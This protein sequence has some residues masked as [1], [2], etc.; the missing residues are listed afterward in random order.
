MF[1][2]EPIALQLISE[3]GFP[4]LISLADI[5][6]IDIQQCV[7]RMFN[8]LRE[9]GVTTASPSSSSSSSSSSSL[10]SSF[11]EDH[12]EQTSSVLLSDNFEFV[13]WSRWRMN[14][15][16]QRVWFWHQQDAKLIICTSVCTDFF[17]NKERKKERNV[18]NFMVI[19]SSQTPSGGMKLHANSI[20]VVFFVVC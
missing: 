2:T 1:N 18:V 5:A 6:D 12:G 4:L 19:A 11:D 16:T 8:N 3:F 13:E 7:Q 15:V 14:I 10:T 9:R 20:A 17:N